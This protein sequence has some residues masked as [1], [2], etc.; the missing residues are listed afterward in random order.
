MPSLLVNAIEEIPTSIAAKSQVGF[1]L[2]YHDGDLG[3]MG[4]GIVTSQVKKALI[5]YMYRHLGLAA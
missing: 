1:L 4:E 5:R 3:R 2:G